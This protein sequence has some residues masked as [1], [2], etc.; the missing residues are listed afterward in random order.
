MGLSLLSF[1]HH[2]IQVA[3]LPRSR[4][5][6][7]G[8]KPPAKLRPVAPARASGLRRQPSGSQRPPGKKPST[9]N[10]NSPGMQATISSLWKNFGYKR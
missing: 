1:S 2:S 10:E 6:N 3:G 5:S 7:Q 8:T 4:P 9:N